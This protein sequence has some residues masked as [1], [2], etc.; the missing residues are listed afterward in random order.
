[1]KIYDELYNNY[2]LAYEGM[3]EKGVFH[4]IAKMQEQY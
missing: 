1:V 4:S 2:C 3:D